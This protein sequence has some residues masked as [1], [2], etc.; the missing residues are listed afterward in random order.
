M[1][2]ILPGVS[3]TLGFARGEGR[4]LIDSIHSEEISLGMKKNFE[5]FYYTG[6]VSYVYTSNETKSYSNNNK[7]TDYL[8]KEWSNEV[9][10]NVAM[11]NQWTFG[12]FKLDC[13][14]VG[15]GVVLSGRNETREFE[16]GIKT[17]QKSSSLYPRFF[18]ILMKTRIGYIF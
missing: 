10:F 7:R 5:T 8:E 2:E 4:F 16:D 15:V 18:P 1:Q 14:W 9:N 6:R 11:G 13:E 12:H 3:A 17:E